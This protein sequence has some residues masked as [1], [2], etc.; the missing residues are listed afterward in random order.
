M[1]IAPLIHD[2][3]SGLRV[4]IAEDQPA[5]A[6]A[7]QFLL[8]VHDIPVV[9]ANCPNEALNIVLC[10]KLGLVLQDMNF[11][12]GATSGEDGLNLFRRIREIDPKL[13]VLA[14]TAWT[15]LEVAVQM[16]KEGAADYM[17]KPWNDEKL[18]STVKKLLDKRSRLLEE[19]TPT[20]ASEPRRMTGLH[21][22]DIL[23]D[24]FVIDRLAGAGGMGEVYKALDRKTGG[25]VAVKVLRG[26][27]AADLARF[28]R[29][30]RILRGIDDPH[31]VRHIAQG[32][33]PS[34]DPYLVMEWLDG[35]DLSRRLRRGPFEFVESISLCADIADALGILHDLGIVHRDLKPSNV[36]LV[37]DAERKIKLLDF[38]IAWARA[39]TR[40]TATG[41]IIGTLGYMAPELA[42]GTEEGDERADIFALGCLLFECLTGEQ[43]Y[44]ATN[45]MAMLSKLLFE[46]PPRL[47]A[48][49]PGIPDEIDALVGRFMSSD[50]DERPSHGHRAAVELRA[51]LAGRG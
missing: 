37:R 46:Q 50:R 27:G 17:A 49:M 14:I 10:E 41:T 1:S 31:V 36:F 7:L 38:G 12:D 30:A 9:V 40:V 44:V 42:N 13:P 48:R 16:V 15:S 18:I 29:E 4:L 35:E 23:E 11:V 26:D 8:E 43:A 24:R 47:K 33:A 34:G 51:M 32:S 45:P 6:K 28:E 21:R 5:V 39:S 2:E 19:V 20:Q 22:G 3:P 25:L